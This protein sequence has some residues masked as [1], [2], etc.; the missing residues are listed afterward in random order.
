ML[1]SKIFAPPEQAV[2]PAVHVWRKVLTGLVCFAG[3][4]LY[5]AALPPFNLYIFAAVC[6]L[7]LF[8][9]LP[10]CRFFHAVTL[11]W[12][13]GLGWS[14]FSFRFLREI[15]PAAPWLLAPVMALWPAL[16]A[17]G[18]HFIARS[19]LFY[20]GT[21]L[22]KEQP[23]SRVLLLALC[24]AAL[25]VLTEWTR[26]RLF[27][28]NDFAV[29]LWQVPL[30]LQISVFTGHYGIN[31]TV[32]LV[33]AAMS[34]AV[35]FRKKYA[36]LLLLLPLIFSA[37]YGYFRLNAP[38]KRKTLRFSPALIQ[39]N[40]SQRRHASLEQAQEALDTYTHLTRK[41][42]AKGK[43]PDIVLWP[44]SSIP[45]PFYSAFSLR[46]SSQK[47]DYGRLAANYQYQVK[48][49]CREFAVP[50]MIGA[51][52][53]EDFLPGNTNPGATNSALYFDQ[54]GV[55]KAK[56]DKLH[57]V[58]FGEYVPFRTLLPETIVR[59]IDMGR[60]LVP[61]KNANPVVLSDKVRAGTAICYEGVFSYVMRNFARRGANVFIVLSNDAWYPESSEPEQHLANAV[62][63]S[64]ES[65]LPMIRCGNNGGSGIV[66]PDG[67]YKIID[68]TKKFPR[69]ELRRGAAAE[70]IEVDLPENPERTFYV[71]FG[72]WFVYLLI[73]FTLFCFLFSLRCRQ[74]KNQADAALLGKDDSSTEKQ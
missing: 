40:L 25:F 68:P 34:C 22:K 24:G 16:F 29:T 46:L 19:I 26:S 12:F 47:T 64:V 36:G 42:L 11:G 61:G 73:F 74:K 5:A 50:M 70:I 14:L 3:G 72:E 37:G 20:E 39:G 33:N 53:F 43:K 57:R 18:F 2:S 7:P 35:C 56:Y 49:L 41:L 48:N 65:N 63:R 23:Y 66:Y 1:F 4:T 67:T 17:A 45:I 21:L 13:W 32:A 10:R 60:D 44:E 62:L 69:P 54:W 30:L 58:P 55:L 28:W 51:L 27:P 71:R 8:Y 6:L 31:F 59:Y 52:D 38:E 15:D 9:F